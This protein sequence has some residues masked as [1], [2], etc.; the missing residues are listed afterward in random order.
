MSQGHMHPLPPFGSTSE[1]P[2]VAYWC[3]RLPAT[4]LAR[5]CSARPAVTRDRLC[6][7]AVRSKTYPLKW[8][9]EFG[10]PCLYPLRTAGTV[11]RDCSDTHSRVFT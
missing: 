11:N 8:H 6:T 4:R 5:A 10:V 9:T 2:L 3:G 1:G 7:T